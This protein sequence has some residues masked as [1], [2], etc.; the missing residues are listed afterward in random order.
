[1]LTR[2]QFLR[3]LITAAAGTSLIGLE[4]AS[5]KPADKRYL[6]FDFH[7]HPGQFIIKG[8]D[9][10]PGDAAIAK[11]VGIMNSSHLSGGFFSLVADMPIINLGPT[12]VVTTTP[13]KPGEAWKEYKRQLGIYRDSFKPT[14]VILSTKASDLANYD[15]Q[16]KVV[17]YL[18]CEGGDML[19]NVDHVDETYRDGVRSIQLVHYSPNDIGDLQTSDPQHNGLSAFGKEVVKRMNKLGMVIDVAHASYN[20][21]KATADITTK[22]LI[23]SHSA[24]SMGADKPLARRTISVDHAKVV[25]GTGGVIGMWPSGFFPTFDAFVEG[26]FRMIDA[27]GIDH[28]GLGTDMDGNFKP[29]FDNYAQLIPWADALKAKGLSDADTR[30]V[31]GENALRVLKQVL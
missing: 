1:M 6:T 16:E 19:G 17:A 30:K 24:M 21:V 13:Y 5:A 27:A 20:T 31:L 7:T 29:V 2:N 15:K 9:K 11:T 28:V 18:G 3:Q 23:L 25:A 4:H 14:D 10:F 12:G 26:T 22:P 8:S